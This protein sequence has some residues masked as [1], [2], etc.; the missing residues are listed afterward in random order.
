MWIVI[1]IAIL[2]IDRDL[3]FQTIIII[4]EILTF[5]S[6]NE[7]ILYISRICP[8]T[9]LKSVHVINYKDTQKKNTTLSEHFQNQISKS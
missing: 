4:V 9:S 7:K 5:K 8:W 2:E 6:V 1:S 3:V